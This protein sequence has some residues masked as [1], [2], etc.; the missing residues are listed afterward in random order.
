MNF[1]FMELLYRGVTWSSVWHDAKGN[2]N[3]LDFAELDCMSIGYI[4]QIVV[5]KSWKNKYPKAAIR[6]GNWSHVI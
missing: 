2:N 5:V 6:D 3:A 4:F 1:L